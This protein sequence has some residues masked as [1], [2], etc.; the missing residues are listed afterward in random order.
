MTLIIKYINE[1]KLPTEKR[2]ARKIR[3]KAAHYYMIEEKLYK[4][5]IDGPYLK[6]LDPEGAKYVLAEVHEGQCSNHA[7]GRS[8]AQ[9]I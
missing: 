7:A 4:R 6:C 8:L 1:G 2:E 3:Q 9:K 5:S